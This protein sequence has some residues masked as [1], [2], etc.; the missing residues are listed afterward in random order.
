MLLLWSYLLAT[1]YWYRAAPVTN[2]ASFR[3]VTDMFSQY[4]RLW[5]SQTV[6]WVLIEHEQCFLRKW[7]CITAHT[8]YQW[9]TISRQ[10]LQL[11]SFS[12]ETRTWTDTRIEPVKHAE[13]LSPANHQKCEM[14]S[15]VLTN[16]WLSDH[17]FIDSPCRSR[18]V[19]PTLF[20]RTSPSNSSYRKKT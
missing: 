15:P 17:C 13:S 4:S 16:F 1:L 8:Q 14:A 3:T 20:T 19:T 18:A 7:R 10:L 9:P 12:S 5:C 6:K 11:I 2:M